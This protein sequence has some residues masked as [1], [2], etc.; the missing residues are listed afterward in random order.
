MTYRALALDPDTCLKRDLKKA[1]ISNITLSTAV[2][3]EQL[4]ASVDEE[5]ADLIVLHSELFEGMSGLELVAKVRKQKPVCLLY[6]LQ[7][8][9]QQSN[10]TRRRQKA[11]E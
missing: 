10:Y 3:A 6:Y 2:N 7:M 4:C 11:L 8:I 9:I 5:A 1:H